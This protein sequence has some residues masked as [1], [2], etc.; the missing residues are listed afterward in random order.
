MNR[1]LKSSVLGLAVAATTLSAMPSADAGDRWRRGGYYGHRYNNNGDLV[2]A[3]VLGLAVG[4]LAA[5]IA[6]AP[7]AP[8]YYEEYVPPRRVY[9][10]A[11]PRYYVEEP[12]VAYALE[13]WSPEWYDYCS[14]RYRSFNPRTGTFT[15]YDGV[16]RFCQAN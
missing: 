4:A 11:P 2:A 1:L 9:R 3:G 5:G 10:T 13:P 16:T 6:T 14:G 8:V 12:R 7:R 15:G